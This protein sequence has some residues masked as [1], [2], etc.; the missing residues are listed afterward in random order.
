[1]DQKFRDEL[2]N[3]MSSNLTKARSARILSSLQAYY[4]DVK[5][6]LWYRNIYELAI[7]VVLSA[8]TTDRQVNGASEILFRKYP[9]FSSL[10]RAKVHEVEKIIKSTGFYRAKA[11]NIILLSRMVCTRFGGV[12]PDE[13]DSLLELP[14]VGRKSA[15][16]ILSV[17]YNKPG[18]AVDTHVSRIAK[19]LGYSYGKIPAEVE[20]DLCNIIVPEMWKTTHLLFIRHG[21]SIC[22]ARKPLCDSCPVSGQCNYFLNSEA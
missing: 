4:G 2:N 11:K 1:M 5:P 7:A 20:K 15:N 14:G 9:D 22:T 8:Q 10:A 13:M 21:R 3:K 19:R 16:V 12:V 18:L 6:D 17:G